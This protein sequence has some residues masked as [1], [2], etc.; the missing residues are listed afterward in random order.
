MKERRDLTDL[1][2]S[3]EDS[4]AGDEM[5]ALIAELYPF[6]RSITGDG[7][8][9]TLKAVRERIPIEIY[10][11][12]TGTP[13][14]D[15]TVPKEWNI[16]DAY[17][18]APDGRKI[19]DFQTSNL[20]IV[21]YSVPVH[22]F[23][24]L[25]ELKAHLHT[26]PEHPDW[27]PYR[28][29]YYRENWGFCISHRQFLE[30]EDGDYEVYIDSSLREGSLTYA[31][32]V[33]PGRSDAEVLIFSHIC[34][35]SLCNDNLSGIGVATFLALYLARCQTRYTYRF[36]FAPATIGSITWLSRNE[37]SLHMIRHGLVI[38]VVGDPGHFRYKKTYQ[39]DAEIDR[40][41]RRTLVDLGVQFE[42]LEF[43]PWGYD[44]RQ[45]NSPGIR[46][47]VGRLTRSPNGGYA[48]YH[49]SAD[50]LNLVRPEYLAGSL[51]AYLSIMNTLEANMCYRNEFPK[52]EPQLGRRGLYRTTG[53]QQSI[54]QSQ[55]AMLWVLNMSDG[56][57]SLLDIA[58][59]GDLCFR[60]IQAAA[61]A[62][63][64]HGVL[65]AC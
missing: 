56:E 31:E 42:V 20:H 25:V 63:E 43:E 36:V 49:T 12:P 9:N 28:T 59:R 35:P 61:D 8:R 16:R 4:R 13:V 45:F 24:P 14:F 29:S 40:A 27:V 30:L 48:E 6:C 17:I 44:E 11:V 1:I 22:R 32:A 10:E 19:A 64:A 7:V 46:L 57:H 23:V 33:L 62:L 41:V 47:P 55:L 51:R 52:G 5:Y 60:D 26:I 18:R 53:G 21:S 50:D 2:D 38:S 37:R 54:E 39:G 58:E 3:L 15:W 34:H 65:A